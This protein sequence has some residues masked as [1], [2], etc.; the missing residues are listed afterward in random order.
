M[1]DRI[2]SGGS[3]NNAMLVDGRLPDVAN[4]G[5]QTVRSNVVGPDFF[6]TLGVPVLQGRDFKDSDTAATPFV[7]IVNEEF[8]RRFLPGK[9]PLGHTFG[10]DNGRATITIVGVVKNHKYRSIDEEPIPMAWYMYAQIPVIGK[11]DVEMRVHGAPLAI[12]PAARKTVQQLDPNLPLINPMT[13]RAQ[14]DSTIANQILFA[15]LAGFFGILAMALVATGLYGALSYRVNMRTAEIGV[16]MAMGAR[17]GQVVWMI[18]KDSLLLTSAG[19]VTGVP[20]AMLLGSVLASSLYGVKALDGTSY[21]LAVLGVAGVALGASAL[22]AGRAAS[23]EPLTA[24]RT[25]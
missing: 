3:E 9:N 2:G 16:R 21:L 20:L 24:L 4:G 5:S 18:L 15:R 11:M 25:E 6:S 10:P 23:V 12:L 13:Q 7:G 1:M 17:R 8:A 14:Y 22:P 19:V